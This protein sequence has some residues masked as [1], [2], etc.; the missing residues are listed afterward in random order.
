MCPF[1]RQIGCLLFVHTSTREPSPSFPC[2]TAAISGAARPLLWFP[3]HAE[4]RLAPPV[5]DT[6]LARSTAQLTR[7]IQL[8]N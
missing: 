6:A 5:K 1:K 8:L 3:G 2:A 4:G 7:F